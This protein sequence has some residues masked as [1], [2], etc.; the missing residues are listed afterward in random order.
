MKLKHDNR[1]Q[2]CPKHIHNAYN[3]PVLDI[4]Y[5]ILYCKFMFH[6]IY[7]IEGTAALVNEKGEEQPL[8]AGDFALVNPDEK[9]K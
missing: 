7:I 9:H 6:M 8:K 2:I 1:L 4:F 5:A 3:S